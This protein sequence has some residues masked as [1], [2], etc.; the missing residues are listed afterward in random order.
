MALT[1]TVAGRRLEIASTSEAMHSADDASRV[2][3][4]V[5]EDPGVPSG[6]GLLVDV[7]DFHQPFNTQEVHQRLVTLFDEL[8]SK[9]APVCAFVISDTL[10]HAVTAT[11]ALE[12]GHARG[13]R[14]MICR[15]VDEARAWLDLVTAGG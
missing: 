9:L 12:F 1:Y 8:R 15:S 6:V 14:V 3:R 10:P 4:R 5:R 2:L 11:F 7:R 13:I